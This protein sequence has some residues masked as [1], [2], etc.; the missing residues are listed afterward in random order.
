MR[1]ELGIQVRAAPEQVFELARDVSAW[2]SLLP[3]YRR[4]EVLKRS[5]DRALTQF[6]ALRP[7]FGRAA[8]P[9]TWRAICWSDASD[10]ND[11]RLHF[12]H[13]RGVTRG[14]LVTWRIRPA[15]DA[16]AQ[17]IA[18]TRVTIQHDFERRIGPL[19]PDALPAF[20]DRWF[21]RPIASR[22]LRRFKRLA[23]QESGRAAQPDRRLPSNSDA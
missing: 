11:L 7:V 15:G 6:V 19:G 4:S 13:V 16:G 14:M 21:T 20:V 23:E 3:H 22:T 2:A 17:A 9:V 10:P 8:I 12:E 18:R 5:A 1:T